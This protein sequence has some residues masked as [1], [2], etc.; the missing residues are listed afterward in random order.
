MRVDCASGRIE[1]AA[2]R[3]PSTNFRRLGEAPDAIGQRAVLR[4]VD[5]CPTA[6]LIVQ[7]PL[8]P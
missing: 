1:R 8:Q 2:K 5:G 3:A 7:K 6:V 4:L